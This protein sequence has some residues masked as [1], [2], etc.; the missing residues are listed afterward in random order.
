VADYGNVESKLAG[1]E[2]SLRRV[3]SAI[4]QYVLKDIRFGRAEDSIASKNLGGGFFTATTPVA[5]NTEF[6]ISHT[7]GRIPYLLIPV[8][9][10][11]TV[12]AK[13]VRLTVTQPADAS[14]VF[15]SS[16]DSNCPIRVFLEG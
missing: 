13:I 3:L 4:F 10:L 11:D 9:P 7:F 2:P 5:I 15:L 12:G 14:R 6:V 16:P 8:L 1:I